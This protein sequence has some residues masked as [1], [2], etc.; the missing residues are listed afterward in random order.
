MN[1]SPVFPVLIIS[2]IEL[3]FFLSNNPILILS[4]LTQFTYFLHSLIFIYSSDV[5]SCH[6]FMSSS[7]FHS[8]SAFDLLFCFTLVFA[9]FGPEFSSFSV[10]I[11]L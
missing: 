6:L 8:S 11:L 7:F 5:S 1:D 10:Q 3:F 2:Y 4:F 9:T